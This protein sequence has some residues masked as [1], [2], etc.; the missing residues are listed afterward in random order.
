MTTRSIRRHRRREII[1]IVAV[2]ALLVRLATGPAWPASASTEGGHPHA[3][4]S[5]TQA[6]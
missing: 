5:V 3:I 6:R 4:V 2:A 1:K